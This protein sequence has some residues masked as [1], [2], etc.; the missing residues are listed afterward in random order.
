MLVTVARFIE[1]SE[2][3]VVRAL[4]DSAGLGS[5]TASE[6]HV[7]ADYQISLALGGVR[8][9]VPLENREEAE[10]L[11]AS[12][13]RGEL[14]RDLELELGIDAQDLCPQ[15]SS[16][17]IAW[18]IPKATAFALLVFMLFLF[19]FPVRP[20]LGVCTSCGHKWHR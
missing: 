12:Y 8:I 1:P 11:V 14:Q 3:H 17:E 18:R 5:S 19:S 6:H 20:S 2:A 7:T 15:C 10:A 13:S 16:R 4:L 9:Q